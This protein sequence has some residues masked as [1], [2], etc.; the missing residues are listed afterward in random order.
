MTPES[1][2]FDDL[3]G[4]LALKRY[5]QP[6]PGYFASFS[7]KVLARIEAQREAAKTSWWRRLFNGTDVKP[8]LVCAYSLS[9][10]GL[11]LVA[12]G[13]ASSDDG[14][15]AGLHL[16][17]AP[18]LLDHSVTKISAEP[19]PAT[20]AVQP[21]MTLQPMPTVEQS[22]SVDPVLNPDAAPPGLFNPNGFY[23]PEQAKQN[24]LLE[25]R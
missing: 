20:A 18:T 11:L 13:L 19:V 23:R 3:K 9:V 1:D 25:T 2:D 17:P 8:V 24:F 12:F 7:E 16:P 4:L 22:S 15:T 6:P 21:Q 14:T 10:A 5:E